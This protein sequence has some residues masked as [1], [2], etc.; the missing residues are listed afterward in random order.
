MCQAE[1]YLYG[2]HGDVDIAGGLLAGLDLAD[3]VADGA[4]GGAFALRAN[5]FFVDRAFWTVVAADAYRLAI[6]PG[7]GPALAAVDLDVEEAGDRPA[8]PRCKQSPPCY[9]RVTYC[10]SQDHHS[11]SKFVIRRPCDQSGPGERNLN[12]KPL[13]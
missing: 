4:D 3:D 13:S 11:W 9:P 5:V 12:T 1:L 8:I 6:V 7:E 10:G 2:L